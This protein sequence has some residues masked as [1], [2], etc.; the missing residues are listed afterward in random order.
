MYA[1]AGCLSDALYYAKLATTEVDGRR[2]M[3]LLGPQ[4]PKFADAFAQIRSKPLLNT[5][6]TLLGGGHYE[7]AEFAI[8]Q[9]LSL[10]PD[11][12]EAL[13][14]YAQIMILT[15]RT[16]DAIG[17]LRSIAT[18]AGPSATLLSRL[19]GCLIQ[20]GQH[21]DGLACHREAIARTPNSLTILGAA[22][23]D[24]R[25]FG[26]A[27]AKASGIIEDW[28]E[29]LTASAPKTVRPAP[30][31]AGTTPV[32]I[33]YLCSALDGEDTRS[34]IGAIARSHDR[35][36]VSVIGF[37]R[38]E[39]E[40]AANEWARGAFDLWRD[41]GNL[42]VTTLGALIRG[43]G[44]HVVIDADGALAPAR[45]G[46]F[47]R[48]T[49]PVQLA[50]LNQTVGGRAPGNYLALVPGLRE[51]GEGELALPGGRYFLGDN[52]GKAPSAGIGPFAETG[53][54]TFGAEVLRAELNP[55]LALVWGRILQAVPKSMLLL[56]DTGMLSEPSNVDA[57]I[58]MFG[59][60][61][62]AHRIDVIK[63]V[64]RAAFAASIDI[65]LMPFPAANVL[66][67]GEFLR[68]G[69]PVLAMTGCEAGADMGA[70]LASA[71]LAESLVGSDVDGYAAA[72]V[73]LAGDVAGLARLRA[74]IPAAISGVSSFSAKGFAAMIE[75]AAI[76]ALE[77]SKA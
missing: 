52:G 46:L 71:G 6:I 1:E 17:M 22:V 54:I 25:Y 47:M 12:V 53:T 37:G 23:S 58:S 75:D 42:D 70:F 38:G 20:S 73:A 30:K 18:L 49:A 28:I 14:V 74:G 45:R 62:V 15:G 48:N 2:L 13:D 77:R 60:V 67:Y 34:M 65:A 40:S 31:Y 63:N 50:W 59:N 27:E 7:R 8:E 26:A 29:Q 9:H 10:L 64:D 39:V 24:L 56:R 68:S 72:A 69:A 44:I 57:L 5:A 43:E 19:G 35:S 36:R 55:H 16:S 41:V 21:A 61:G 76:A 51:A 66:A 32:R 4:F 33:C 11:D 3:G